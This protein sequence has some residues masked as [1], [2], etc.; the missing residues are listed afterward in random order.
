MSV[1]NSAKRGGKVCNSSGG[2]YFLWVLLLLLVLVG[3]QLLSSRSLPLLPLPKLKRSLMHNDSS[4]LCTGSNRFQSDDS[5]GDR[6]GKFGDMM[7]SML[8]VDLPFSECVNVRKGEVV[9]HVI[10]WVLMDADFEQSFLPDY[11]DR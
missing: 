10:N 8:P 2:G 5:G 11:E 9:V 4:F 1:K 3:L 7:V 6:I